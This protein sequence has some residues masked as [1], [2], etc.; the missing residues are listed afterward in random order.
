M[1]LDSKPGALP[2]S[3]ENAKIE[4]QRIVKRIGIPI[5]HM[6]KSAVSLNG[7]AQLIRDTHK[8]TGEIWR[9]DDGTLYCKRGA[10]IVHTKGEHKT[11]KAKSGFYRI[12][13]GYRA[14]VWGFTKPTAD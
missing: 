9:D 13:P 4:Q 14:E 12:Q 3:I 6:P 10:K 11:I 8:V 5:V 7:E 2:G 1:T